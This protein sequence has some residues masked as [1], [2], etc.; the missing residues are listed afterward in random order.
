VV[1]VNLD[2][3]LAGVGPQD[4]P[5]VLD[6][7]P[8]EGDRRGEE[9][10]VERHTVESLPHVGTGGDQQQRPVLR[11]QLGKRADSLA[12]A[13]A[14]AEHHRGAPGFAQLLG[15]HVDVRG[16]LGQEHAVAAPLECRHDVADQLLV[17]ALVRDKVPVDRGNPAGCRGIGVAAVDEHGQ[18]DG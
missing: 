15:E 6:Q 18:M 4:P 12:G 17:A 5:D 10:R 16:P 14:T 13:H 3:V 7:T 11:P 8:P 9:H 2:D 1:I